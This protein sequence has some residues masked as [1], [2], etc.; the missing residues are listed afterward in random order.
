[1]PSFKNTLLILA[2]AAATAQ[3]ERLRVVWSAGSFSALAG[4]KG[5][6]GGSGYSTNFAIINEDGDAIYEESTP[7][8]YSPCFQYDGRDFQIAGDCWDSYS[9][10][11]FCVANFAG[12]PESCAVKDY[13]GNVLDEGESKS[14]I[15]FKG[16]AIDTAGAC[17]AEFES[18]G[19]GCPLDNDLRAISKG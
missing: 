9:F 17:V 16:I 1:M 11:F 4:P 19:D 6:G 5:A 18:D 14:N 2:A 3:A 15:E 12:E 8:D 13:D 10:R 7:Y